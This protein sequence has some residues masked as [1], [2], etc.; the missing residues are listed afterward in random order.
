MIK[1]RVMFALIF[2]VSIL[3]QILQ[4][5]FLYKLNVAPSHGVLRKHDN[6]AISCSFCFKEHVLQ[7][8]VIP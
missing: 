5:S 8:I 3:T 7:G 1:N 4:I 2:P 6:L